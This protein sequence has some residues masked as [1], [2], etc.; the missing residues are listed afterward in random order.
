MDSEPVLALN[1]INGASGTYL[2]ESLGLGAAAAIATGA[3]E[4]VA[5]A[6]ELRLWW[7][8]INS[9]HLGPVE[10]VNPDDLAESGWGVIFPAQSDPAVA[11]ALQPLLELRRDQAGRVF[12]TFTG[13]DGVQPAESKTRFLARHGVS[14]GP[15]DP[16]R[17]PYYLLLVGAPE[18][19]SYRFQ[20]ELDVTYAVGRI[21]F[22]T[23][24]EYASYARNVVA[25]ERRSQP[26][27]AAFVGVRNDDDRA[28]Q[29]SSDMLVRP[30]A[31]QLA[32]DQPRWTVDVQL[33][34]A[35]TKA[36]YRRFLG[37]PDTPTLFFSAG[38]GVGFPPGHVRQ[39]TDQGALLCQD[40][41]GPLVWDG[42]IA[43]EFYFA[44]AD[45]AADADLHGIVAIFFACYGAGT[46]RLDDFAHRSSGAPMSIA[47][48]AF[49]ASLPRR[50]LAH[51]A[52]GALAV[53]GH[54][55]RTWGYSFAW[56][57]AGEQLG[58]LRSTVTRLLNGQRVGYAMEYMNQRYAELSS[59]LSIRLEDA[60][61]DKQV[62]NKELAGLWT[63]HNDAR[64]F[65][66]V[67][68]TAVRLS[69]R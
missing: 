55:D 26:P 41:P 52:G 17:V 54:V 20:Y 27:R 69:V 7:D 57:G 61:W 37:G 11:A 39:P 28:T 23:I 46:P 12:R 68:D 30:L 24:E 22:D 5:H 56:P 4:D 1:G 66:V 65:I 42:P 62:D 50:M 2:L 60:K 16:E 10:G 59:A 58:A 35:A 32:A 64:S 47:P 9:L 25:G 67:G 43:P 51:P 29:L 3:P 63:A 18:D 13:P 40:W 49:L 53:I 38:H 8:R 36:T 21:H 48:Q 14:F 15:A 19:I 6:R 45:V 31:A 44:A 33:A 34:D